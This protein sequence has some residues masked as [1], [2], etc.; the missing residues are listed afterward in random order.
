MM[1]K[2]CKE[3]SDFGDEREVL[4]RELEKAIAKRGIP[5]EAAGINS[6]SDKSVGVWARFIEC[7]GELYCRQ[8]IEEEVS[9]LLG[10]S[11]SVHENGCGS[12]GQEGCRCEYRLLA[13]GAHSFSF[14]KAQLA[15]DGKSSC[16]DTGDSLLL[17]DDF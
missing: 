7:P 12:C 8:A 17:D 11:F 3:I 16:G 5:V 6:L 2:L 1:E 15:K 13:S 10:C 4:E 9:R 14:G